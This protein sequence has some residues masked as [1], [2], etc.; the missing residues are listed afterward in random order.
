[1]VIR[2][3]MVTPEIGGAPDRLSLSEQTCGGCFEAVELFGE[4]RPQ[5]RAVQ[6]QMKVTKPEIIRILTL[7][8]YALMLI[9]IKHNVTAA[10]PHRCLHR[11]K[12]RELGQGTAELDLIH[13]GLEA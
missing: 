6:R 13:A 5:H 9:Q 8:P 12:A 10:L 11:L 2:Q 1:M 3:G 7:K 4:R